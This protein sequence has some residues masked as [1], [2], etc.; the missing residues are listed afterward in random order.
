M[1][2]IREV[3]KYSK[4]IS[5]IL[6]IICALLFPKSLE[7][8]AI[9]NASTYSSID[10]D[11][12]LLQDG[13]IIFRRGISFVSNLVLENDSESPYSH[14]GIVSFF[15]NELFV[16]HAVPDES[17]N[18]IDYVRKDPLNLFLRTDR[19][20]AFAVIRYNNITA[21]KKASAYS[22]KCYDSKILFDDEFSLQD[23]S[24]LYCTEL[25]WLAFKNANVNLTESKFDTLSI[26]IGENPYLLPGTI[27]NSPNTFQV[28]KTSI[29]Q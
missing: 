5:Y 21:A 15:N 17:E 9:I 12:S 27:L 1:P 24:K 25:V 28:T 29:F 8:R 20:S 11:T 14:V 3:D 23:S 22:K 19:A 7:E 2:V 26:P 16:I 18:G 6:V 13:D 4:K 10:I